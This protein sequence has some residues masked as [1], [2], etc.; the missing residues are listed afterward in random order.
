[1]SDDP[2]GYV[3]LCFDSIGAV[4]RTLNF[5][6]ADATTADFS[7]FSIFI[8]TARAINMEISRAPY[9]TTL[10]ACYDEPPCYASQVLLEML[11]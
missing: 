3:V 6:E 1:M 11:P 10:R 4:Q 2:I 9:V 8:H 7:L 5:V